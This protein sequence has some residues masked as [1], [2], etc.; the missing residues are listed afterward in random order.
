MSQKDPTTPPSLPVLTREDFYELEYLDDWELIPGTKEV[1]D[2]P[3]WINW[4]TQVYSHD[5]RF[6]AVT[7]P[8]NTGDGESADA[9]DPVLSEVFPH[10]EMVTTYKG[11]PQEVAQE[12]TS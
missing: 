4:I 3:R 8:S 9:Y 5:G 6:F 7:V 12:R 10:T 11:E 2:S 1:D